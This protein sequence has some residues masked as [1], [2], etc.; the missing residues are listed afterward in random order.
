[1]NTLQI[2]V[3]FPEAK[4]YLNTTTAFDLARTIEGHVLLS[5]AA[6]TGK[7]AR[8]PKKGTVSIATYPSEAKYTLFL[9]PEAL[10]VGMGG[11]QG[12]AEWWL[13]AF[14]F[15]TKVYHAAKEMFYDYVSQEE[16]LDMMLTLGHEAKGVTFE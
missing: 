13:T 16:L 14:D 11:P 5:P 3:E 2:A 1:M 4:V 10:W 7:I 12:V 8:Q 6:L 15:I 9:Y